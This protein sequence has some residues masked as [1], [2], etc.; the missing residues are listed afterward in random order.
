ME[1]KVVFFHSLMFLF[2]FVLQFFKDVFLKMFRLQHP[3]YNFTDSYINCVGSKMD[4]VKPFGVV[5]E[6]LKR[7][8][9]QALMASRTFIQGLAVGRNVVMQAQKVCLLYMT[10]HWHYILQ[11]PSGLE[12]TCK[13]CTSPTWKVHNLIWSIKS[14]NCFDVF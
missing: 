1:I 5:P 4:D 14:Q 11:A 2:L 7:N 13:G 3:T 6:R 9:K 10:S 12:V 8:L